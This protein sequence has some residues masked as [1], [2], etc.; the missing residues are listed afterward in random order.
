MRGVPR[1]GFEGGR[2][3]VADLAPEV[4]RNGRRDVR[5][6]RQG[7]PGRDARV[8]DGTWTGP[9]LEGAGVRRLRTGVREETVTGPSPSPPRATPVP[10]GKHAE[11]SPPFSWERR[12]SSIRSSGSRDA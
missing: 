4:R 8:R 11:G 12:R 7:P 2:R 3:A 9:D 1:Q 6:D 5:I 10:C